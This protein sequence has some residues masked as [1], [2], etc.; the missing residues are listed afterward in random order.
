LLAAEL[1]LRTGDIMRLKFENIDLTGKRISFVQHKTGIETVLP[2]SDELVLALADYIKNGRPKS[3]LNEIF[4]K[5][6]APYTAF[7][8][9]SSLYQRLQRYFP[10]SGIEIPPGTRHG[11]HALRS[12]LASNMLR[13]GTTMP[14]ISNILGHRSVDTASVYLKIDIDGLRRVALEVPTT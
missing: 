12:S 14:V 8:N 7:R 3:D 2:M 4:L 5:S 13:V 10:L 6:I 9:T 11:F 1:G